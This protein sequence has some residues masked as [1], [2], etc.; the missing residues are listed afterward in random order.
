MN[1]WNSIQ[2]LPLQ[3]YDDEIY[4][5][6]Q[7][8]EALNKWFDQVL[9]GFDPKGNQNP[10]KI[11]SIPFQ[12]DPILEHMDQ[13]L[14][15]SERGDRDYDSEVDSESRGVKKEEEIKQGPPSQYV[16]P[17]SGRLIIAYPFFN[18]ASRMG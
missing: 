7:A 3:E 5:I 4:S 1:T 14:R 13:Q 9:W 6:K 18:R 10:L 16:Y 12:M 8:T 17:Q 2:L 15:L 11:L